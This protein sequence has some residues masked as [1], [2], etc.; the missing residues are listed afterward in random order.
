MKTQIENADWKY[1]LK[2][3][4]RSQWGDGSGAVWFGDVWC[5][6]VVRWEFKGPVSYGRKEFFKASLHWVNEIER[7]SRPWREEFRS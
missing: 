5:G 6:G 4:G 2:S 7:D 3:R 1:R